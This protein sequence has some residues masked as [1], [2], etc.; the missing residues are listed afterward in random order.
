MLLGKLPQGSL[1][2]YALPEHEVQDVCRKAPALQ[3]LVSA[4]PYSRQPLAVWEVPEDH[5]PQKT[6]YL[7]ACASF[8]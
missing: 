2:C 6:Q 4:E 1:P 5:G 8:R 7:Y 3:F